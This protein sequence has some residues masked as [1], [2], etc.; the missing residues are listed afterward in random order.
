[1]KTYRIAVTMREDG[2]V[3]V[4]AENEEEAFEKAEIENE[5]GGFVSYKSECS[6]GEILEVRDN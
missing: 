5:A 3:E 2:Y 6:I 1:M 4:E